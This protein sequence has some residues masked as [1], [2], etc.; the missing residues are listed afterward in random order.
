MFNI[1]NRTIGTALFA[2]FLSSTF[3]NA[4]YD[5]FEST[6]LKPI[7]VR[8]CS[9]APNVK[10]M[11]DVGDWTAATLNNDAY[12]TFCVKPGD[13]SGAADITITRSGTASVPKVIRYYDT[14]DQGNHPVDQTPAERAWIPKLE[15]SGVDYWYLTRLYTND[16]SGDQARQV[17][18]REQS[19]F[20]TLDQMYMDVNWGN[21]VQ[22]RSGSDDI[23][24]Q[25]S[26]LRNAKAPSPNTASV[27]CIGIMVN[28]PDGNM[29]R[30]H[31][32][33]NEIYDC[34]EDSIQISHNWMRTNFA[35]I[36]TGVEFVFED[37]DAFITPFLYT[38][39]AGNYTAD[40][41]SLYACS[42]N[43][44]DVKITGAAGQGVSRITRN[45]VWGFRN[46]EPNTGLCDDNGGNGDA[47]LA[48]YKVGWDGVGLEISDNIIMDSRIGI[49]LGDNEP[50]HVSVWR[51]L[52]Y[53][54]GNLDISADRIRTH[55]LDKGAQ[56]NEFY[57]NL[58]R[59][60]NIDPGYW[61]EFLASATDVRNNSI[62]DTAAATR[63][64]GSGGAVGYN[65]YFVTSAYSG[66]NSVGNNITAGTVAAA[67][68]DQFCFTRR[69][70]S[71]PEWTCIDD[72]IPTV[73]SPQTGNL[74]TNVGSITNRGISDAY[75]VSGDWVFDDGGAE[76]VETLGALYL[77]TIAGADFPEGTAIN[78]W[79]LDAT[80]PATTPAAVLNGTATVGRD[81]QLEQI[82][83]TALGAYPYDT[84][85]LA[86]ENPTAG[87]LGIYPVTVQ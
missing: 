20:I 6:Y 54:N 55:I 2:V 10:I 5:D 36:A 3:A 62:V 47:I 4:S 34:F 59:G 64:M 1:K 78:W 13:Y 67:N 43:A 21:L 8:T 44:F 71:Q 60:V 73:I 23:T 74:D 40:P 48:H 66:N 16:P 31:I 84:V 57:W 9:T 26:V 50:R 79:V 29:D 76:P 82:D 77:A 86:L 39:G 30:I 72:A 32:I 52:F 45:R 18:I 51:N 7:P 33:S 49:A 17:D 68:M 70:Y 25:K 87:Y 11:D 41:D 15:F 19:S 38:D 35:N 53:D 81:S 14:A 28:D 85:I 56:Y 75:P 22:I 63:D 80:N 24:V 12:Q 83:V 69:P 37:N 42:E 65:A 27:K 58:F 46:V 61:Y